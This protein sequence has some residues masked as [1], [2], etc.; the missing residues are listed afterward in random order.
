GFTSIVTNLASLENKGF[1]IELN[2][3]I[4]PASSP[5]QWEVSLNAAKV[6]TTITKLPEN[7]TPRNRIGGVLVWDTNTGS[8]EWK[9]GLQEGGRLG[10]LYTY[11][12]IGVFGSDAEAAAGPVDQIVP[13][14]SKKK[15]G[16]DVNWEDVD[17]N[18]II[19]T[20]DQVY[21]GNTYPEW[22]GGMSTTVAYKGFSLYARLDFLTGTTIMNIPEQFFYTQASGLNNLSANVLKSWMKPGDE[23]TSPFPRFYYADQQ[24]SL[25]YVRGNSDNFESGNFM[26]LREVTLSYTLPKNLIKRAKISNMRVYLTGNNLKYFTRYSGLNPEQGGGDN[27]RYP[28]PG[29]FLLGANVNF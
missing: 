24:V 27:G 26:N 3:R 18:G 21:M 8:Y 7:G 14:A 10:D 23:K 2:S 4:L 19:D 6:K 15:Y 11:H 5:L 12:K 22:T 1:E 9:G 13:G 17:K 20:R 25:N 28:M 16:G 29:N